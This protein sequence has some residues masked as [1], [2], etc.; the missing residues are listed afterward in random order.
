MLDVLESSA[1]LIP[2]TSYMGL[3]SRAGARLAE[4]GPQSDRLRA[5]AIRCASAVE[6]LLRLAEWGGWLSEAHAA[7]L[8]AKVR[9]T[10]ID[11]GVDIPFFKVVRAFIN[12]PR[13]VRRQVLQPLFIPLLE[14][15]GHQV[16]G[17]LPPPGPLTFVQ[18]G[19]V[20]HLMSFLLYTLISS[21]MPTRLVL[22]YNDGVEEVPPLDL[23]EVASH[24]ADDRRELERWLLR[25][26]GGLTA[27]YGYTYDYRA[28]GRTLAKLD[29]QAPLLLDLPFAESMDVLGALLP[30][31]R[32]FN[33]SSAYGAPGE[34]CIAYE[35]YQ[36]VGFN[37]PGW[38]FGLWERYSDSAAQRFAEFLDR[39]RAFQTLAAEVAV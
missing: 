33:L 9:E 15:F 31:E 8:G 27:Q 32:V 6:S 2:I 20:I 29:P 5:Y 37:A 4:S 19:N 14:Y 10:V 25:E 13:E 30:F 35:Y 17:L 7:H 24:L 36:I 3:L 22:L 26:F 18:P 23:R 1:H 28:I 34:V 16:S 38:R 11:R 21:A 12:A 39:L